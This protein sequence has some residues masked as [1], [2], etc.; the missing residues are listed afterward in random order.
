[1]LSQTTDKFIAAYQTA[2]FE[3]IR[4]EIIKIR[5]SDHWFKAKQRFNGTEH[6]DYCM[7]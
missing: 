1:M 3:E 2:K 7:L 4:L 6:V 5:T